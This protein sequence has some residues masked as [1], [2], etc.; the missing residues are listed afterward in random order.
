MVDRSGIYNKQTEGEEIQVQKDS[1]RL[2]EKHAKPW[3]KAKLNTPGGKRIR[4]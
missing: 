2:P 3:N 4:K 1:E